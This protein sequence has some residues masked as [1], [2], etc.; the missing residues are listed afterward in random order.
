MIWKTIFSFKFKMGPKVAE[1]TCNINSA[2]GP[3]I[4]NELTVQ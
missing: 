2:F 3:A 1:T 4:A